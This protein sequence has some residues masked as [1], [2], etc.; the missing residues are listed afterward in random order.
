[1]R[2]LKRAHP[3]LTFQASITSTLSLLHRM[4]SRAKIS[5]S[6]TC[7]AGDLGSLPFFMTWPWRLCR[8]A[9][10]DPRSSRAAIQPKS[11]QPWRKGKPPNQI[12]FGEA[13]KMQGASSS[14][15]LLDFPGLG[16]T[17]FSTIGVAQVSAILGVPVKQI[18]YSAHAQ[19]PKLDLTLSQK[20]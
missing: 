11:H 18:G 10:V 2:H 6:L 14:K 13:R 8:L 1:M 17:F 20:R 7:S 4:S 16:Y 5:L 15:L 9:H 19:K 12:C 3:R